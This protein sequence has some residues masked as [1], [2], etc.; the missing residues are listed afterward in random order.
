MYLDQKKLLLTALILGAASQALAD[1]L[2]NLQATIQ[3]TQPRPHHRRQADLPAKAIALYRG[4]LDRARVHRAS[5]T[6]QNSVSHLGPVVATCPWL[7]GY[8]DC[9]Q[10]TQDY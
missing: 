10:N 5:T 9:H 8:P 4:S 2:D 1:G 6:S 7:E 3:A